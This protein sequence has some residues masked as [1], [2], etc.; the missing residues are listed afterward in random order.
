M[1]VQVSVSRVDIVPKDWMLARGL[2][3]RDLQFEFQPLTLLEVVWQ[4]EF[5]APLGI[6]AVLD[7]F[8]S[9]DLLVA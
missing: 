7:D 9:T 1:L 8:S 5:G 6:K 2:S 4:L 3:F